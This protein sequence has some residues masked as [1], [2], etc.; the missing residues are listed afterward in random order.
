MCHGLESRCLILW[1]T[2]MPICSRCFAI[3]AGLLVGVAAFA[4]LAFLRAKPLPLAGLVALSVPLMIDGFSQAFGLRE[5][6][7]E[8]R[9]FTG[10]LAGSGFSLWCLGAIESNARE[11]LHMLRFESL[12]RGRI[13]P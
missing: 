11:R 12:T 6:V 13:A 4:F 2:P 9:I 5:S 8:L 3:Y 1:D 7:N 10:V